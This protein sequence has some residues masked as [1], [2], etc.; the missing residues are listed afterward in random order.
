M[1]KCRHSK[2]EKSPGHGTKG[3]HHTCTPGNLWI[4]GLVLSSQERS[5]RKFPHYYISPPPLFSPFL[6]SAH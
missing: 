5:N 2:R 4:P 1:K 3:G 6:E